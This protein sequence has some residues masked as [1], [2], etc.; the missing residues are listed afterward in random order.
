MEYLF[1]VMEALIGDS[2]MVPGLLTEYILKGENE[3]CVQE[4][5]GWKPN[6]PAALT[7]THTPPPPPPHPKAR[8]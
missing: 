8:S 7:H 4:V 6:P 3:R 2:P 5:V 1:V